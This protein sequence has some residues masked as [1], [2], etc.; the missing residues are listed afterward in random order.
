MAHHITRFLRSSCAPAASC[1]PRLARERRLATVGRACAAAH[2][3]AGP[4]AAQLLGLCVHML[5]SIAVFSAPM[6]PWLQ[7]VMR[8]LLS[9]R[10][11]P[12][13]VT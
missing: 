1:R 8:T 11:K 2:V 7:P 10:L 5:A 12:H 6:P 3:S 13:I 4:L 9:E